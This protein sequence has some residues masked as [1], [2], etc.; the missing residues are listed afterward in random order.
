MNIC[1]P[2]CGK[3]VS[4]ELLN[5]NTDLG[6]CSN[7]GTVFK[8]S[9][10]VSKN[11]LSSV[12]NPPF[13]S[14]IVLEKQDEGSIKIQVP[15]KK[16]SASD[17]P[18]IFMLI[19]MTAFVTFWTT[20]AAKASIFSALFSAPFWFIIIKTF[21]GLINS[22]DEDQEIFI[23]P[24]RITINKN[25]PIGSKHIELD[26]RDV[27]DVRK[28]TIIPRNPFSIK[29]NRRMFKMN[30]LGTDIPH[31]NCGSK[32]Y[33]FF[34]Y[35]SEAEKSWVVNFLKVIINKYKSSNK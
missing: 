2:F 20:N 12:I 7:C 16:F 14:G 13:G 19:F 8:V 11:E 32:S 6:K 10:A 3:I 33:L 15:A 31:L 5:V 30:K 26:L 29:Y 23:E 27:Y 25:R 1:C 18:Q 9:E 4:T 28:E 35:A 17:L 22:Y 24:G 21:I 34:E